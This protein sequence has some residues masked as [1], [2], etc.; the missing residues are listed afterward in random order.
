MRITFPTIE[1]SSSAQLPPLESAGKGGSLEMIDSLAF[2]IP[3]TNLNLFG[4]NCPFVASALMTPLVVGVASSII[5][6]LKRAGRHD[7]LC[8]LA[9][10]V[11][12][13]GSV[14]GKYC[15]RFNSKQYIFHNL[16]AWIVKRLTGKE[17]HSIYLKERDSYVTQVYDKSLVNELLSLSPTYS[18]HP[19]RPVRPTIDYLNYL[20]IDAR[21]LAIRTLFSLNGTISPII[22]QKGGYY[23]IKPHLGVGYTSPA[24]LLEEYKSLLEE[25]NINLKIKMDKQYKDRG[26]LDTYSWRAL[27]GLHKIGGFID[28]A[29]IL[30]GKNKGLEK[31]LMLNILID[32]N[33]NY[34]SKI[35]IER[36]DELKHSYRQGIL[37]RIF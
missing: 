33:K 1:F 34:D 17:P 12:C 25:F 31:N 5:N 22:S 23:L 27:E 4:S 37:A 18:K 28:G 11:L 26:F 10:M 24:C 3:A 19:E 29:V 14:Y 6:E 36:I 2:Y 20:N 15:I 8:I 9:T 13:K 35:N 32:I 30:K 16:F 7:V 21:R